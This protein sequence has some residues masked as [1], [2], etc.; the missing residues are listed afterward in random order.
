MRVNCI[1][2]AAQI[3]AR[4]ARA[5]HEVVLGLRHPQPDLDRARARAR[6]T[7]RRSSSHLLG[8]DC[9]WVNGQVIFLSGDTLALLRHPRE[10][11]FAFR[12]EGWT[13][14]DLKLYFRESV[15]AQL[16]TPGMVAQR[17]PWYDGVR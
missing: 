4:S 7:S 2:P 16:E 9:R 6:T 14:D 3:A 11:R 5:P 1:N 13:L 8:D 15:G 12:P 17:Y 10:E